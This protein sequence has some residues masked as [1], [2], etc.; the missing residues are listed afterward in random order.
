M[1]VFE[2]P[3]TLEKLSGELKLTKNTDKPLKDVY[4]L[5]IEGDEN[6]GDYRTNENFYS[7]AEIKRLMPILAKIEYGMITGS[8]ERADDNSC[9]LTE[10]EEDMTWDIMPYSEYG[11]HGIGILSFKYHDTNGVVYDVKIDAPEY[12]V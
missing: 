9:E 1:Q 6:D 12:K 4:H 3:N 10:E 8:G 5:V 7:E 11:C 2:T